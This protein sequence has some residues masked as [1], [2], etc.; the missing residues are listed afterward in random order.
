MELLVQC[1]TSVE[2]FETVYNA[3]DYPCAD[4]HLVACVLNANV[5]TTPPVVV[6]LMGVGG[7][8]MGG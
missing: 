5:P 2:P 7:S 3:V 8:S 1:D 4:R 6:Q